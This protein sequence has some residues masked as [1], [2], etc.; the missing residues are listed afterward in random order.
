M[1]KA[2][3]PPREQY[4]SVWEEIAEEHEEA[5]EICIEEETPFAEKAERLLDELE[6]R[7]L[8]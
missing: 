2:D 8:R 5:L 6:E 1:S 3:S 4:D 7:G